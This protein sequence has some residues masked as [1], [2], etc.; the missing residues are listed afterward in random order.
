M[1]FNEKRQLIHFSKQYFVIKNIFL[2]VYFSKEQKHIEML[3]E[4]LSSSKSQSSSLKEQVERLHVE[5]SSLKNTERK[6]EMHLADARNHIS[7][8]QEKIKKYDKAKVTY[9]LIN[10]KSFKL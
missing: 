2:Y 4:E 9:T 1:T 7:E 10:L 5:V 6:N 3:K 8:L